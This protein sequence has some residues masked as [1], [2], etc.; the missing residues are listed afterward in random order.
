MK[1]NFRLGVILAIFAAAGCASL[2]VVYSIMKEKAFSGKSEKIILD[3]SSGGIGTKLKIPKAKL[4]IT[5]EE[6]MK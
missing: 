2:A 1:G 3:P 5:I 6:T 4:T